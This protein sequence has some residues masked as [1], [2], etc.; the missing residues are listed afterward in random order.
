MK[1]VVGSDHAGFE[2]KETLKAYLKKKGIEVTDAGTNGLESVDYPTFGQK[3]A[4]T[5]VNDNYD[6][7]VVVCGTGIGISIAANK[8]KGARAAL[9]YDEQTARLAKQHNN[10]NVIAFGGRMPSASIATSM[11]DTFIETKFEERHQKRVSM[12]NDL[13]DEQ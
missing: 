13:I 10:A 5:V 11:L 3:V 6:F 9:I 2:L 8:V 1:V 7:G 12:L 4:R